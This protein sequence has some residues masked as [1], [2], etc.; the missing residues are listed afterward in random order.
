[1]LLTA[2]VDMPHLLSCSIIISPHVAAALCTI[3]KA[4]CLV[5]SICYMPQLP[6]A[7]P[8][9]QLTKILADNTADHGCLV[10]FGLPSLLQHTPNPT[11]QLATRLHGMHSTEKYNIQPSHL[12]DELLHAVW[13]ALSTPATQLCTAKNDQ[14]SSLQVLAMT[15]QEQLQ[16]HSVSMGLHTS[17][18]R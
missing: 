16:K 18:C 9:I 1:M 11:A 12:S 6:T 4:P 14:S 10:T 7:A 15:L 2:A 5:T 17:G 3:L 13:Y 8:C